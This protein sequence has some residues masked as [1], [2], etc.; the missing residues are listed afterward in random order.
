MRPWAASCDAPAGG[1]TRTTEPRYGPAS[2]PCACPNKKDRCLRHDPNPSM[3]LRARPDGVPLHTRTLPAAP[4]DTNPHAA[5][6]LPT[7]TPPQCRG[8]RGGGVCGC[9]PLTLSGR[10]RTVRLNRGLE[11]RAVAT[12]LPCV[13]RERHPVQPHGTGR[14]GECGRRFRPV[15]WWSRLTLSADP[16]STRLLIRK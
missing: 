11:V 10:A 13:E 2:L 8:G 6:G 3:G 9:F 16:P 12:P 5:N 14:P 1:A 7:T 15:G 4:T